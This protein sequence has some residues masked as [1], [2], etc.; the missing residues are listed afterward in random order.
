MVDAPANVKQKMH[1]DVLEI[2]C[3][4][5]RDGFK[6]LKGQSNIYEVQAFGD[7]LNVIV[8]NASQDL[9]VVESILI[10]QDISITSSRIIAPSLENVFISFLTRGEPHNVPQ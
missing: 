1:G 3:D 2:V 10:R 4:R 8:K 5:V 9:P 6:A 7:R